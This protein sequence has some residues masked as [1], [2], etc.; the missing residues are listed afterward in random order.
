MEN[1]A[2]TVDSGHS[3]AMTVCLEKP[4]NILFLKL[5]WSDTLPRLVYY[6]DSQCCWSWVTFGIQILAEQ[7]DKQSHK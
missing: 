5:S 7:T 3:I 2:G 6:G 4:N 1:I